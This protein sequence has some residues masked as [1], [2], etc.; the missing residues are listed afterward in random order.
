MRNAASSQ[1]IRSSTRTPAAAQHIQLLPIAVALVF[2]FLLLPGAAAQLYSGSISGTITDPSG[3]V[4]PMAR[5]NATDQD[6]GFA[7]TA[8][9]DPSGRYLLRPIPLEPTAWMWKR[10]ISSASAATQSKWTS[11]RTSRLTSL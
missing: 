6:K 2:S 9:T 5:V 8:T 10:P 3:A 7:F 4:I 1:V 11:I